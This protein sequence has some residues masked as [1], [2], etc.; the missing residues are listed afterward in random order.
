MADKFEYLSPREFQKL[1]K[2][3]KDSYLLALYRHLHTE[4]L[5]QEDVDFSLKHKHSDKDPPQNG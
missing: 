3:E 4:Y 1:G 2:A 5:T